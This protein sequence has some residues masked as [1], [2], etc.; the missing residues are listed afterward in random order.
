[1]AGATPRAKKQKTSATS[2][3]FVTPTTATNKQHSGE[4][5]TQYSIQTRLDLI[6]DYYHG[7]TIDELLV[8]YNVAT[9]K[10]ISRWLKEFGEGR[11]DVCFM[12]TV[13]RRRNTFKIG[14]LGR[15]V[16][17]PQLE[18]H[19]LRFMA[20]LDEAH[21]QF[22]GSMLILEAL[23]EF[24]GWLGGVDAPR[25]MDRA[26]QYILRFRERNSLVWR[27]PT[28][29]GQKRPA[30]FEQKWFLCAE[31]YYVK[32][33]GIPKKYN[34]NGDETL[35]LHEQV[36]K[37]QIAKKGVKRVH[38]LTTGG[39]KEGNSVYLGTDGCGGKVRP[40]ILFKGSQTANRPT[41]LTAARQK[42]GTIRF[43]VEEAKR[44]GLV[45]PWF[46]FWVNDSGTMNEEAHCF[47]LDRQFKRIRREEKQP[48]TRMSM[49]E[50]SHS[51]H[52]TK[53]VAMTCKSLNV[54]LAIISGGL[55][56]DAQL[57]D[58]VFIKRFKRVHR[59]KLLELMRI[60]WRE[61]KRRQIR[62]DG[63][64]WRPD[65]LRPNAP[66][67]LEQ[68][69]LIVQAWRE[70]NT[71]DIETKTD[72][73]RMKCYELA[74]ETG[75]TP[76][77]AFEGI[78]DDA[79]VRKE[80][81]H[82]HA[83]PPTALEQLQQTKADFQKMKCMAQKCTKRASFNFEDQTYPKFCEEHKYEGMVNVTEF[84]IPERTHIFVGGK[85]GS[86]GRGEGGG[87]VKCDKP[88]VTKEGTKTSRA[89]GEEGVE[90]KKDNADAPGC[91][92]KGTGKGKGSI[93]SKKGP[94]KP[95][96]AATIGT[97]GKDSKPITSY[98][99]QSQ[100]TSPRKKQQPDGH[101]NALLQ[102]E[103]KLMAQEGLSRTEARHVAMATM[104]SLEGAGN[105]VEEVNN[106]SSMEGA[107]KQEEVEK[108]SAGLSGR[109]QS[110]TS[111]E[112]K[113]YDDEDLPLL[114][115]TP[116][117]K[118]I[119]TYE[120]SQLYS[121][122]GRGPIIV[123]AAPPFGVQLKRQ[124]FERL[125]SPG[126]GPQGWVNDVIMDFIAR[127]VN[128]IRPDRYVFHS[129]IR[130]CFLLGPEKGRRALLKIV[131]KVWAQRDDDTGALKTVIPDE[132]F[133]PLI[134][135]G[136]PHW[137]VM[138][139]DV[140]GRNYRVLDPFCPNRRAPVERVRVAEELLT[141]V[142]RALYKSKIKLDE[143]EYDAEYLYTL[144][145]QADGYNCGIYVGIYMLMISRNLINYKWPQNMDEF[146]WRLA[147]ALD[148][149]DP[150]IFVP[151]QML[152]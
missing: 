64:I 116:A 82:I 135:D 37:K 131:S 39:E 83:P 81:E 25:F 127:L 148:T 47:M 77:K 96:K 54:Q 2:H 130:E 59:M 134:R 100:D 55:T 9:Q 15:K 48:H 66:D 58:R 147:L 68:I 143:F 24:P 52:K 29:V 112:G 67:R 149:N 144:P 31:F 63:Y 90:E 136:D 113:E 16:E 42:K 4:K 99:S 7:V 137:W 69:N 78:V 74:Q 98:F 95:N 32:T 125:L 28:T 102:M 89:S 111:V 121:M 6:D 34:Y 49:L 88:G 57:G 119:P 97:F 145:A 8:K 93:S 13:E 41:S 142:L 101:A 115:S 75:W 20:A 30:G 86:R 14:N 33:K 50:D 117:C 118:D 126:Q 84:A 61:A 110:I 140:G 139:V 106:F 43:Q 109:Q 71:A 124:D 60:K 92:V 85:G 12:W 53:R 91:K 38:A 10:S 23:E 40:F 76:A 103:H 146:R 105:K 107:V 79:A 108:C 35:V 18:V 36:S 133:F 80:V 114:L 17:N 141:W 5:L 150:E 56:G 132:W 44:K 27:M 72:E 1:M 45:D 123:D 3:I 152:P 51:S 46:D 19:L 151:S 73:V 104:A 22:L 70:T 122:W 11:Y 87:K 65:M 128:K 94:G 138:H 120:L 62:R 21:L 129:Y 26:H